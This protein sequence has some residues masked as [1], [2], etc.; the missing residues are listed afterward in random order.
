LPN[1]N[2][3]LNQQCEDSNDPNP[4]YRCE[5]IHCCETFAA[6]KANPEAVSI[7]ECILACDVGDDDCSFQCLLDHPLGIVDW[8]QRLTCVLVFCAEPE[9]C[10]AGPL[11]PC[12]ECVTENCADE[13]MACASNASCFLLESCIGNSACVG[14]CIHECVE[15]YPQGQEAFEIS[16]T[17]SIDACANVCG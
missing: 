16:A 5:D 15:T 10:G 7:R 14:E 3:L 2:P 1:E 6:Y 11:D 9:A 8:G 13:E 17:C 4:C 12:V